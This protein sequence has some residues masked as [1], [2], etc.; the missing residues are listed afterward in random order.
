M[1]EKLNNELRAFPWEVYFFEEGVWSPLQAFD[2]EHEARHY[3]DAL[4]GESNL[5]RDFYALIG[6]DDKVMPLEPASYRQ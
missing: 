3:Y 1:Q 5:P 4:V 2:S 6:P